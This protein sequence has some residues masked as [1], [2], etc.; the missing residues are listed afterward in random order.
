MLRVVPSSAKFAAFQRRVG[1]RP[2]AVGLPELLWHFTAAN[3]P[4]GTIGRYSDEEIEAWIG[5]EGHPGALVADLVAT[6]FLDSVPDEARLYV[7]D[8]HDHADRSVHMRLARE[9]RRFGNG[10]IPTLSHL[11]ASER[12]VAQ[13]RYAV[14]T[15]CTQR[16]PAEAVGQEQGQGQVL[17]AGEGAEEHPSG[18]AP[19]GAS[20]ERALR[21]LSNEPGSPDAKRAWL[22]RELPPVLAEAQRLEPENKTAR[23]AAFRSLLIRYWRQYQRAPA[24]TRDH[25]GKL[26]R[27]DGRAKADAELRECIQRLYSNDH[28]IREPT[29]EA[30]REWESAGRPTE[31]G[32]WDPEGVYAR[33]APSR[34]HGGGS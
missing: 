22:R 15:A 2:L 10:S 23:S 27:L 33:P 20:L 30:F 5:W 19:D 1:S 18:D 32:W 31:P 11:P 13:E 12:S 4:D 8:W 9:G 24:L 7:H 25:P 29:L 16:P 17:R 3:A 6:R 21:L 26:T 28:L 34:S 14:H